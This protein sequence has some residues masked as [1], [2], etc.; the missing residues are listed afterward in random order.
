MTISHNP[1]RALQRAAYR[2]QAR[3]PEGYACNAPAGQVDRA[4]GVV[5]CRTH[6]TRS[7]G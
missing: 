7:R 2:C 5:V 6:L 3:T 1:L 4:T